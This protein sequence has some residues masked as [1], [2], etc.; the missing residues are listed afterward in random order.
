MP[1]ST[2][3]SLPPF[4]GIAVPSCAGIRMDGTTIRAI[5]AHGVKGKSLPVTTSTGEH[6]IFSSHL[7]DHGGGIL[8]DGSSSD[9]VGTSDIVV[10]LDGSIF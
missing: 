7:R 5:N 2:M 4:D 9:A 6:D 3:P 8:S 10:L 1:V